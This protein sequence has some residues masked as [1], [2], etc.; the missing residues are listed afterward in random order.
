MDSQPNIVALAAP[1]VVGLGA[2]TAILLTD[3][4]DDLSWTR[5]VIAALV[6]LGVSWGGAHFLTPV[7]LRRRLAREDAPHRAATVSSFE[8]EVER[9]TG[10]PFPSA[11]RT[12]EK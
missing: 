10:R 12:T 4:T 11:T 1:V 5:F 9:I 2:F 6:L 8:A 3:G 7:L